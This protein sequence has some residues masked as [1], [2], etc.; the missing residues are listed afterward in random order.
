[1][2]QKKLID[3]YFNFQ[4]SIFLILWFY[5]TKKNR[6]SQSRPFLVCLALGE[7]CC[8]KFILLHIF[9]L[10]FLGSFRKFFMIFVTK[11]LW[12]E[13]G[14]LS[15]CRRDLLFLFL[16]RDDTK[17]GNESIHWTYAL[18]DNQPV[19]QNEILCRFGLGPF[20]VFSYPNFPV[21]VNISQRSRSKNTVTFATFPLRGQSFS[22]Q[23]FYCEENSTMFANAQ[24]LNM[25]TPH[26]AHLSLFPKNFFSLKLLKTS[27]SFGV[28]RKFL[29]L[30][31]CLEL[32]FSF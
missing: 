20:P 30:L 17:N 12:G 25:D 2:L 10:T 8:F 3:A 15:R 26:R 5:F 32:E 6:T 4:Q 16:Y 24:G 31:L 28:L 21:P 19:S 18:C 13:P 11:K 27:T 22:W 23:I 14:L 29:L 9:N 1:M 7:K